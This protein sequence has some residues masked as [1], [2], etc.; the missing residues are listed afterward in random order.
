ML[1]IFSICAIIDNIVDRAK[2]RRSEH[3]NHASWGIHLSTCIPKKGNST[4]GGA[5]HEISAPQLNVA[6]GW[7]YR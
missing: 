2:T 3:G 1:D 6:V 7:N 4:K 5:D